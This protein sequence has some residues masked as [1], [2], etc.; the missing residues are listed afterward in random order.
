MLRVLLALL[1]LSFPA[2]GDEL[3]FSSFHFDYIAGDLPTA[4][5]FGNH[6]HPFGPYLEAEGVGG[7][8]VFLGGTGTPTDPF[9]WEKGLLSFFG[10][11]RPPGCTDSFLSNPPCLTIEFVGLKGIIDSAGLLQMFG[12]A[13]ATA[14]PQYMTLLG[15]VDAR[16]YGTFELSER[17][18]F[19]CEGCTDNVFRSAN[20]TLRLQPVPEPT[21]IFL[22]G[23]GIV[24]I[25]AR[26][27]RRSPR[28]VANG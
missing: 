20:S 15:L 6:I 7:A 12:S 2:W 1:L 5:P 13:F 26:G 4:N 17:V 9:L 27:R 25:A 18:P 22:I 8:G 28:K 14:S 16:L 21:T 10:V 24:G 23:S 3:I 19:T 11:G